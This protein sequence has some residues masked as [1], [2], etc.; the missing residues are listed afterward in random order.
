MINGKMEIIV[1]PIPALQKIPQGI[2]N[3]GLRKALNKVSKPILDAA[4]SAA[5][6]D[7]GA[8]KTAIGRIVKVKGD[9]AFS[10]IGIKSKYQKIKKG[11]V[12]KPIKYAHIVEKKNPYIANNV[13]LGELKEELTKEVIAIIKENSA[14]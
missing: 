1:D 9:F 12:R 4:K 2:R 11:V 5:P 6:R 3:K 10:R 14:S 7:T 8:L 13:N